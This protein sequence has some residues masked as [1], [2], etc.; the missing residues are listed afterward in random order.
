MKL[1]IRTVTALLLTGTIAWT[2]SAQEQPQPEQATPEAEAVERWNLFY[3]ATSI[4]QYHGTFRS[5]YEGAF[6]L[7]NRM[8]RDASLTTTLFLGL[9][10]ENLTV[11]YFDSE[12]A[13]GRGFS[14]VDGL[15]NSSN[16]ELP[17]VLRPRQ[18]HTWRASAPLT[19]LHSASRWNRL[20]ARKIS[21]AACAP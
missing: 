5:P 4:G 19:T 16:G 10:L 7:Q 20:R 6:S 11:L 12:T 1:T 17:R 13:G 2:A 21:L 18:N 15:A 14:G 8:E 9:R 3:Q